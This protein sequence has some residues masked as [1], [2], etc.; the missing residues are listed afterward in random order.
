MKNR[1]S[2][3][4]LIKKASELFMPRC[5]K[6][7]ELNALRCVNIAYG[8]NANARRTTYK[9]ACVALAK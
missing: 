9:R 3:N 4:Y 7:N 6:L 1:G 2:M 8:D 5:N